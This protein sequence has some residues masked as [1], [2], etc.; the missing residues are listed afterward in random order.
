[1]L[2]LLL[3]QNNMSVSLTEPKLPQKVLVIGSG[4]KRASPE[5]SLVVEGGGVLHM[6]C[7]DHVPTLWTGKEQVAYMSY[8]HS[9]FFLLLLFL[10]SDIT[11]LRWYMAKWSVMFHSTYLKYGSYF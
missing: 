9:I 11:D 3:G 10:T 8:Y 6:A 1:M 4:P 7:H 5:E 2:M